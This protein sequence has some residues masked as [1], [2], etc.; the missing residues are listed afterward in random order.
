M[1]SSNNASLVCKITEKSTGATYLVTGDKENERWKRI[2][3]I[4]GSLIKCDVLDAPHHGSKNGITSEAFKLMK[5][6]VVLISA[7]VGNKFGHP[8]AEAVKIF[9]SLGAKVHSTNDGNGQSIRTEITKN[10]AQSFL[11]TVK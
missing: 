5:P 6:N 8:D 4:F 9:G 7:G 11:Y 1:D 10:G 3:A 2:A